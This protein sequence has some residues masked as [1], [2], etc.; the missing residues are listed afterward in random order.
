MTEFPE[1][2]ADARVISFVVTHA[3]NLAC[4]YCFEPHKDN[5]SK[6]SLETAIRAVDFFLNEPF[7]E[8]LVVWDFIGGE[9]L[10][11]I[12]LISRICDYIVDAMR[13]KNHRWAGNY[14]FSMTSNGI[15]YSKPEVQEFVAR[16]RDHL[17]VSISIDGNQAKQD[18]NRVYPDGRGSYQD[19]IE[20]VRLWLKQFPKERTKVTI[21]SSDLPYL[22]DSIIHLFEQG[23]KD[24]PAG[25]VMEDVWKP[26]DPE[27]F[28]AQL[29]LLADYII[30]NDLWPGFK[31]GLF[32]ED[33]GRPLLAEDL[34][35]KNYC[36]AG[37]RTLAVDSTGA[38]YPCSRFTSFALGKKPGYSVGS[39]DEG[40]DYDR[41]RPF[42]ALDYTS[43]SSPACLECEVAS[44]C[45]WCSAANYENAQTANV[46][47]RTTFHCEMHKAQARANQYF[48]SKLGERGVM[49][50]WDRVSEPRKSLFILLAEDSVAY[51]AYKNSSHNS[52][53]VSDAFLAEAVRYCRDHHFRPVFV[54]SRGGA[55]MC[56]PYAPHAVHIVS[57][58]SEG[59]QPGDIVVYDGTEQKAWPCE[60]SILTIG[61]E[62]IPQLA[63]VSRRVLNQASRVNMFLVDR[64]S[65][66]D[67]DALEY[68]RQLRYASEYLI[69]FLRHGARKEISVI[70]DRLGLE[71]PS[72][73]GAGTESLTLAPNGN[74]YICPAFYYSDPGSSVGSLTEPLNAYVLSMCSRQK[75]PLCRDCNALACTNCHFDNLNRTQHL[76]VPGRMQCLTSKLE[77]ATSRWFRQRLVDLRYPYDLGPDF[78]DDKSDPLFKRSATYRFVPELLSE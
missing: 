70:T 8:P 7:Q 47:E 18:M 39:I 44:G 15:L 41:L 37:Q 59:V 24:V 33:I 36:G 5:H 22:R 4:K 58:A 75:S 74:I 14:R 76:N 1:R 49:P 42:F 34:L 63:D 67:S 38:I 62:L 21:S 73:C 13:L 72:N 65:L 45:N 11:E 9:P 71:K 29:R 52:T 48:W 26:G 3:C 10:L 40:L 54:H 32:G 46:Y 6:M 23:M 56:V 78:D 51:C 60:T 20:N 19:V 64:G 2:S 53:T 12:G 28:E 16:Y 68:E 25:L 66:A 61:K 35:K 57:A 27:L 55:R 77:L 50:T 17:H 31:C 30:D 43:Q 69:E